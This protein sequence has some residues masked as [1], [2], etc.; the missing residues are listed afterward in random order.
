MD[1]RKYTMYI[2]VYTKIKTIEILKYDLSCM[3]YYIVIYELIIIF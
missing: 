2:S 3:R 1:I